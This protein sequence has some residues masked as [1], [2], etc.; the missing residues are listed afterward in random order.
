ME[1]TYLQRLSFIKYLFSIALSQSY[2]PEPLCG[3]SILSFHD[4]VELFL[5]LVLEKLGISKKNKG[6]I[7]YWEVIEKEAKGIKLSLKESMKR[8]NKARVDLKHHGFRPSRLDIE[9]YRATTLAFF[10]ENCPIIFTINF[11]E[12]TLIDCIT[13][14]R[15][16]ELLMKAKN[17]FDSGLIKDALEN[18]ALS[19]IYLISDYEKSK[20]TYHR[21]PFFIGESMTSLESR[22][23]DQTL[24]RNL[25]DIISKLTKSI[26]AIQEVM[27]ILCI[28]INY[29]KYVKFKTIV[30][31]VV[32][33]IDGTPRYYLE[34]ELDLNKEDFEFCMTFIVESALKLQ[35]FDFELKS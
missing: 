2:Q 11:D 14:G 16:R 25:G 1:P 23:R 27:E 12:I 30:P 19:F 26:T 4:S 10:N 31:D 24:R 29:R 22:I 17:Y 20:L 34:E 9:L 28:G 32:F 6:F 18:T 13:Y 3:A 15:S 33:A 35:E 8:L 21:S 5:Q 7:D